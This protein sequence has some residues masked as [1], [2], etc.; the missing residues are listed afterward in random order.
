MRRRPNRRYTVHTATSPQQCGICLARIEP[1][2]IYLGRKLFK[3]G[4]YV[5]T[6]R[7][8]GQ[9][10]TIDEINSAEREEVMVKDKSMDAAKGEAGQEWSVLFDVLVN[11]YRLSVEEAG[12]VIGEPTVAIVTRDM[13]GGYIE[14]MVEVAE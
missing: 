10:V 5:G 12:H 4:H 8:C 2:E 14:I 13:P 9:C 6:F 7:K 11:G 1:G 3:E